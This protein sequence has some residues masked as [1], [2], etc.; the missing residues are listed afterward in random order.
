MSYQDVQANQGYD[1]AGPGSCKAIHAEM[2]ALIYARA[3]VV[4]ATLYVT[5][6]PC[7]GCAKHIEAAGIVEVVVA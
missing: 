1:E 6:A 2:N 3:S 7:P 5:R 4:G